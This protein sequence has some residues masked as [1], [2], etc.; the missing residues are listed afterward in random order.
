MKKLV[1][2][3]SCLPRA[4]ATQTTRLP[5]MPHAKISAYRMQNN[6]FVEIRQR[7]LVSFQRIG[8]SPQTEIKTE[9]LIQLFS[10]GVFY[11]KSSLVCALIKIHPLVEIPS[12]PGRGDLPIAIASSCSTNM[13]S[14]ANGKR[15]TAA[16]H[17][18]SCALIGVLQK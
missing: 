2:L 8:R 11:S 14:R 16:R 7:L 18:Q 13:A 3:W 1:T 15:G 10:D 6:T 12:R 17:L 4:T 5:A 9:F